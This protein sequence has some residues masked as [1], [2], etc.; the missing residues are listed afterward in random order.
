MLDF[1]FTVR[2]MLPSNVIDN[3]GLC[4]TLMFTW[5]PIPGQYSSQHIVHY[6]IHY[7]SESS[8]SK[9]YGTFHISGNTSRVTSYT[10]HVS[11][12]SS[13]KWLHLGGNYSFL[14]EVYTDGTTRHF[15]SFPVHLSTP[16]CPGRSA[17]LVCLLVQ[18][19]SAL[20]N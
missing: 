19:L 17:I 11:A 14:L 10:V 20:P 7:H 5:D 3:P 2:L 1:N 15:R 6:S 18:V 16:S 9:T 12:T 4:F 13:M 8:H